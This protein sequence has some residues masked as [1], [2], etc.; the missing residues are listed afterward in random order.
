M[1]VSSSMRL[2]IMRK[3]QTVVE[4][5]QIYFPGK[6]R[7]AVKQTGCIPSVPK[8]SRKRGG[9]QLEDGSKKCERVLWVPDLRCQNPTV[10]SMKARL[11]WLAPMKPPDNY[12]SQFFFL[13]FHTE[14][15]LY[16]IPQSNLFEG[17]F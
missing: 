6:C 11:K 14:T 3:F 13:N 17:Y 9:H 12:Q 1:L 2:I 15:G 4:N 5:E 7:V 10:A 8:K 16:A